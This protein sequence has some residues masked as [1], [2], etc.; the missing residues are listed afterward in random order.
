MDVCIKNINDDDWWA[1]KS[2]SAKHGMKMGEFFS[3]IVDE[4]QEMCSKFTMKD[5]LAGKKT[6][7]NE[8]A[9]NIRKAMKELRKDFKF[10]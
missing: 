9:G 8:D 5:L 2:E 4:H 3:K 6:L 7:T 1:F 10:R